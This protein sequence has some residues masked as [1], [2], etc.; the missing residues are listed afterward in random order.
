MIII[1]HYLMFLELN[2][3]IDLVNNNI[4]NLIIIIFWLHLKNSSILTFRINAIPL[5]QFPNKNVEIEGN[6][7][8]FVCL[9]KKSDIFVE[10]IFYTCYC[11][12]FCYY[13]KSYYL[14]SNL[15]NKLCK[16]RTS[17]KYAKGIFLQT[18]Q[19]FSL[20]FCSTIC[21]YFTTLPS[22][23]LTAITNI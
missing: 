11:F 8:K 13:K 9:Q 12:F 17:K 2:C 4:R 5:F 1:F 7:L 6:N 19:L 18:R 20:A 3:I 23:Q 14:K 16:F 22:E 10:L 21:K 15:I